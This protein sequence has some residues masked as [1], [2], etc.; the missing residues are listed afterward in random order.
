MTDSLVYKFA[1]SFGNRFQAKRINLCDLKP[2]TPEMLKFSGEKTALLQAYDT[3]Q[4]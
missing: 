4:A 1:V 2:K 3:L